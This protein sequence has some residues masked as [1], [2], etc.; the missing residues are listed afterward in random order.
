MI[1]TNLKSDFE[2]LLVTANEIWF[3]VALIKDS[4]YDYVEK[5]LIKIV[6]KII[7]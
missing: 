5:K 6:S 1:I 7:L 4:T 2:K 3:A